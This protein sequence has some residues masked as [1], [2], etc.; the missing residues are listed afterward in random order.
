VTK[1]HPKRL[2]L[3]LE[4]VRQLQI[5]ELVGVYGGNFVPPPVLGP[6]ADMPA[7]GKGQS[8]NCYQH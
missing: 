7:G 2:I 3:N 5:S 8:C 4:T 6:T 1:K